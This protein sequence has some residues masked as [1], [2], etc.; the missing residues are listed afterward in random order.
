MLN[1]KKILLLDIILWDLS[2]VLKVS[3]SRSI[4]IT[5]NWLEMHILRHHKAYRKRNSE[6]KQSVLM[7][8]LG[9]TDAH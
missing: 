3:L 2:M 8:F 9:N 5:K 4:S 6:S 7:K 1:I